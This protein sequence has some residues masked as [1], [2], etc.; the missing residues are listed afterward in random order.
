MEPIDFHEK[1]AFASTESLWS[2]GLAMAKAA[3]ADEWDRAM[4]DYD[5]TLRFRRRS[6][7][8]ARQ[9]GPCPYGEWMNSTERLVGRAR[10]QAL[11][12]I[13]ALRRVRQGVPN[14]VLG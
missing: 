1:L 8:S 12:M 4:Q 13:S 9:R 5:W 6:I 3:G 2:R 14:A 7:H 11:G 10:G